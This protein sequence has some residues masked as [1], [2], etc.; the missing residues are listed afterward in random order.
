MT[1]T[2]INLPAGRQVQSTKSKILNNT[3]IINLKLNI[4]KIR[5]KKSDL[6][7]G[8]FNLILLFT[9]TFSF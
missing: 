8:F 9:A 4:E 2:Q 7:V 5:S 1:K 6:A 3:K